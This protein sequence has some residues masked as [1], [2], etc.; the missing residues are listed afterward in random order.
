MI[1]AIIF[2]LGGV[3]FTNGAK[4]FIDDI[5]ARYAIDKEIVR[6]VI[7]GEIG[8][9]YREGKITRDEFWK[10]VL[11][12]LNLKEDSNTLESEWIDDYKL[13]EGTRD[14]IFELRRK[15]K[16]YYLSDNVRERVMRLDERYGFIKWFEGGIF[17]HE[18]GVRKPNPQIYKLA[19]EKAN[20][21]PEEAVY[22]DDKASCIEPAEYMGMTAFLFE[23]PDKLRRELM[24]K[25]IL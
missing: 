20:V 17:S 19:M 6:N 16:V 3:L 2:D 15:Y 25:G 10:Q 8:T 12:N 18:A 11:T 5:S 1:K 24:D 7:D 22:I 21:K 4:K 13:I 14:I 9:K 23:N